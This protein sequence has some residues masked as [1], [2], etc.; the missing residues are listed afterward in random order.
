MHPL[1]E[2][3]LNE[4]AGGTP[5]RFLLYRI[6]GLLGTPELQECRLGNGLDVLSKW[7]TTCLIAQV[8]A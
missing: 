3:R 4:K 6:Y 5:A 7:D 8:V 2:K 1:R